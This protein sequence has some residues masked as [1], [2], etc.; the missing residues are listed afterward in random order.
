[1]AGLSIFASQIAPI[2]IDIDNQKLIIANS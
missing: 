2:K 1:L